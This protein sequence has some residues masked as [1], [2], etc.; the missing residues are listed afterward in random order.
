[1]DERLGLDESSMSWAETDDGIV[2]LNVATSRYLAVNESGRVLWRA[3]VGTATRG[4]L[5]AELVRAFGISHEQAEHDVASFLASL[6]SQGMLARTS[7]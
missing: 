4:E 3:L 7:T 5:R 6:D 2:V 1:M